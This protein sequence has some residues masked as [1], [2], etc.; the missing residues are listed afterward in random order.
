[1]SKKQ[2]TKETQEIT[3]E[4]VG[5]LDAIIETTVFPPDVSGQKTDTGS[6]HKPKVQTAVMEDVSFESH[7]IVKRCV[8]TRADYNTY[9]GWELP[10]DECGSDEGYL[11]EYTD[12]GEPNH[13]YHTGYISWS[14][15]AQFDAGY[16]IFNPE[17]K[18]PTVKSLGNTNVNGAHK[19]V[20]DLVVY[21]NGDSFRL[22]C[23]ASSQKEGWMK[24]TKAMQIGNMGTLVQV[25][26]QQRNKDGSYT[27]AEALAYVPGAKVK[28]LGDKGCIITN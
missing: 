18:D 7:K 12:G 27:V 3:S 13:A 19:N 14:P 24:S 20:G 8:M 10:E 4:D 9:R 22:V 21:G 26:T 15:K 16:T 17:D 11:V 5:N 2:N 6:V 28:S 23:K 25:T 1:M